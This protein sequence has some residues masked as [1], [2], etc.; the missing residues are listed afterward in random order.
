MAIKP[1]FLFLLFLI[2]A[3]V[4][5]ASENMTIWNVQSFYGKNENVTFNVENRDNGL[6]QDVNVTSAL[7]LGTDT[8]QTIPMRRINQGIYEGTLVTPDA[9][10]YYTLRVQGSSVN[11][12]TDF[13]VGGVDVS[14]VLGV[15]GNPLDATDNGMFVSRLLIWMLLVGMVVFSIIILV[16]GRKRR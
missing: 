15:F 8:L 2:C 10:G 9:T 16:R 3:G 7:L 11:T 12:S 1:T 4:V 14:L 5:Q 13:K 6:L